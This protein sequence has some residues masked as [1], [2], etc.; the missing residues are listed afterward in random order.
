M[1][2]NVD[3]N[4]VSNPDQLLDIPYDTYGDGSE[5]NVI[6]AETV[7]ERQAEMVAERTGRVNCSSKYSV[8]RPCMEQ[9]PGN[10]FTK[11]LPVSQI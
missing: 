1:L 9:Y 5:G 7:E 4:K 2:S 11:R 10:L 6:P 8:K 3:P